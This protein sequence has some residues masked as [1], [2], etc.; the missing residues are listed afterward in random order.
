MAQGSFYALFPDE[1]SVWTG[2]K[3]AVFN[4]G[5]KIYARHRYQKMLAFFEA[6]KHYRE[7]NIMAANRVGK[8]V[9]V[10]FAVA[11]WATGLYPYWWNGIRYLGP[12]DMWVAGQTNETTRDILQR[13]L[14][15]DI[16]IIDGKKSLS[17]NGI[18]PGDRIINPPSW[19]AGVTDLIDTIGV[20][21]LDGGVTRIGMKSYQ[22]G[23][24]SFEGLE[25]SVVVLD[26]EPPDEIYGECLI[27]TMTV[28][29][30]RVISSFTPLNGMSKT[31]LMFMPG[32]EG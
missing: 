11:C 16:T 2:P 20:R 22:Q 8:T 25:K 32:N 31:A 3:T 18:I 12:I 6:T 26:E 14:F 9:G 28:T 23:R 29:N 13:K 19:K 30:G 17:G 21:T 5:D 27:R 7:A 24:I 4:R 1:D 10:G 15:G